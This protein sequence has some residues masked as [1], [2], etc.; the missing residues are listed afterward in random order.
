MTPLLEVSGISRRFGGLQALTDVSFTVEEQSVQAIIGPNG[1]GKTTLLDIIT[2]FTR[3]DR[4]EVSFAGRA[5]TQAEPFRLPGMG[6]MR[7]FQSARLVPRL[8]ARQNIMLGGHYLTRTG[9]WS[10]GLRLGSA[11]REEAALR[12]RADAVLRFLQLSRFADTPAADLPAG[13]QRLIEV[14][15]VLAG[16]PRLAL[17]D[18]PAAGLDDTE[19]KEL[20]DVLRAVKASGITMVIIE[21]NMGLVMSVS[22]R[23]LV[24]DAGQPIA[25]DVPG[26]VQN[27]PK[28]ISAYLGEVPA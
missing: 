20:A 15:R 26:V 10:T 19:T 4:G 17:L 16:S 24:L 9:F 27:D 8:T 13:T 25:D 1:A 28:V 6:L 3:P 23:V 2:G 21:H 11:R 14:G 5:I 22:D 18:E 7:T 12:A